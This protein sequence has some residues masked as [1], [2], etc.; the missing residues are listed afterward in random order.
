MLIKYSETVG[1]NSPSCE[2]DITNKELKTSAVA[3]QY[4]VPARGLYFIKYMG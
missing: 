4:A 1:E 2:Q 3:N